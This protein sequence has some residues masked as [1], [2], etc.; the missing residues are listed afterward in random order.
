LAITARACV[1][2][3]TMIVHCG[4]R[5]ICL[6]RWQLRGLQ[7][8]TNA[9]L[10]Q[11]HGDYEQVSAIEH[12]AHEPLS[13]GAQLQSI[14]D[15]PNWPCQALIQVKSARRPGSGLVNAREG[16]P[17]AALAASALSCL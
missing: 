11:Q 13:L 2:G 15:G 16:G 1:T 6:L 7:G 3:A 5:D 12:P 10:Q 9:E 17:M 14:D 4:H 8:L